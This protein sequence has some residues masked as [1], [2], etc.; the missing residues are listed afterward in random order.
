MPAY[1]TMDQ[2]ND[3]VQH[4]QTAF[5]DPVLKAAKIATNGMGLPIALGG[6]FALT[7]TAST[8]G[9]KFAIRCFHKEAK[10]LENRYSHIDSALRAAGGPY[11]VGFEFQSSGIAVNGSRYPI[12]KMEWVNGDTLGSF[13]EDN[14]AD[15]ARIEKLRAQFTA[16]EKFLRMR[17]IAHGDI[18]NGNVLVQSDLKL[19]DY[20]GVY[21]SS[22]PKGGGSELG[23]KHFQHPKRTAADFGPDMDRFSFIALDVSL[24][25]L[26]H[27]PKLFTKYSN[28]E[29]ILFTANDYLDPGVSTLFAELRSISSI[30]EDV[31]NFAAICVAPLKS[32][33]S[34]EDF[35]ARRNIPV[36]QVTI[37]SPAAA[38]DTHQLIGYVGAF[39]VVDGTSYTA[40]AAQVGNK[41]EL[42]AVVAKV[43]NG[44][45]RYGK[46]YA[47]V[48][49]NDSRTG[50]KLNIWS[51]GMGKLTEFPS[52]SWVGQW[53]SVQGLIDPPYTSSKYGS[54]LSITITAGNQL[55]KITATEAKYRLSRPR[56]V[57]TSG[58]TP[59]NQAIIEA[60]SPTP[61]KRRTS[62]ATNKPVAATTPQTRNR[63]ILDSIK[64]ATQATPRTSQ[65]KA[66]QP[67]QQ[68]PSKPQSNLPWGWI[69]I[70]GIT[71]LGMLRSCA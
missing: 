24:R 3:T 58:V 60:I 17:G 29:N 69:V 22:L 38:A 9:K 52:S 44:K 50:V 49:F 35:L 27:N 31:K 30:A 14:Y 42:V 71:L 43:Y 39:E 70:G 47:F 56:S 2:Y 36:A 34:L 55:R 16:L 19:I 1:P 6:G 40:V 61:N 57:G 67:T 45:T 65:T 68:P 5:S 10:G 15:R 53:F 48:F 41:I 59:R 4:P 26:A 8:Q 46:P 23:H 66:P 11:F 21:V 32:V 62:T 25:A 54:S 63:A 20:D 12:V 7:Y 13:L 28:G 51:E 64:S 37:R 33:P 18:Q